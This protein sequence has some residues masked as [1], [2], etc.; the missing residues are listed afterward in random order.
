[1][2]RILV[3]GGSGFIGRHVCEQASSL[4]C[5][6]TVPTR[7]RNN[8]QT[9]QSLPWVDVIEADIHD[10]A[11][12]TRLV[13]GHDAV[14]NLIAILHGTEAAF[15]RVHV[16]LP[17]KLARACLASGVTRLVH[18]SALG[19]ALDSPARYQRSKAR[20][21]AALRAAALD[22]T[23]APSVRPPLPPPAPRLVQCWR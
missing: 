9:V 17:Q 2:K 1:M 11:V 13:H 4:N 15:E 7:R 19:V 18:I 12:L 21:E 23:V 20:G 16:E 14:V 6:I 5:R 10:E 8:A 3:L 22:L